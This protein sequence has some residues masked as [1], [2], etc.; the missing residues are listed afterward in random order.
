MASKEDVLKGEV[1]KLRLQGFKLWY[2]I[3]DE[4]KKLKADLKEK[5]TKE[6]GPLPT[7][8]MSYEQWY[9]KALAVVRQ[10]TPDRVD[11][12]VK[13]YKDPKRKATNWS[14]Y[15]IS[16]GLLGIK[17]MRGQET[18]VDSA[19]AIPRMYSQANIL[20]AATG[21]LSSV[22]FDMRE[23]VQADIYD[24]E[25]DAARG[26][27][28]AGFIRAAGAMAGVVLEAHL[29][30]VCELHS[31]KPGKAKPTMSTFYDLLKESQIIDVPKW[32]FIQSLAD[33]RN[34]C[35]HKKER[36]PKQD[37]VFEMI[38]GIGKVLKTVY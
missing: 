34:L 26:L 36:E 10:L 4:H 35:D 20:D 22:L 5:L 24:T 28:K 3:L 30:H 11:D 6:H 21:R 25:L 16:D 15:T 37:E 8:N 1:E 31:L 2:A 29:K 17:L 32:R 33:V 19:A 23:S 38:D 27:N 12:F 18:V 7:F 14:T 9:S 13:C